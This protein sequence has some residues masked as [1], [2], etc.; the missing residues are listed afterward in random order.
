MS[1]DLIK[2]SDAI[3]AVSIPCR[4]CLAKDIEDCE[5]CSIPKLK[6]LINAIPSADRPQEEMKGAIK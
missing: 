5:K 1:D 4:T 2:R 3:K 6:E